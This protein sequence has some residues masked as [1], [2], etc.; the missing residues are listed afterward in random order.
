MI[1]GINHQMI[2]LS[3]TDNM[4][5]ERAFLI[6]KPEYAQIHRDILEKEARK[7]LKDINATSVMKK[8]NVF[9]RFGLQILIGAAVGV[10]CTIL[11]QSLLF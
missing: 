1:K 4:Y 10:L 11:V 8:R 5:Y 7:M 2:E 3:Q 6:V 9:L